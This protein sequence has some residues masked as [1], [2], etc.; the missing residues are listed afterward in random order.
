[1]KKTKLITSMI[2]AVALIFSLYFLAQN[3]W[4]RVEKIKLELKAFQ[5]EHAELNVAFFDEQIKMNGS[6]EKRVMDFDKAKQKYNR[7]VTEYRQACLKM[8]VPPRKDFQLYGETKEDPSFGL[9]DKQ[10]ITAKP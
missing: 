2:V 10:I 6:S 1:M 9:P 4:L 5:I 8:N 7:W 3:N